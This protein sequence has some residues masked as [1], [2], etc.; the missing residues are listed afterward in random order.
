MPNSKDSNFKL[1]LQGTNSGLWDLNLIT[2]E[3]YFSPEWKSMLGYE[4]SDLENSFATWQNLMHPD[5]KERSET[6]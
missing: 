4:D 3:V 1:A 2:M 6:F 5:D